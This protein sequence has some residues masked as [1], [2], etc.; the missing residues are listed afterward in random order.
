MKKFL[1]TILLI[2]SVLYIINIGLDVYVSNQLRQS[3]D[4]R[5]VGWNE[6]TQ[7]Q[8]NADMVILGSSRALRQYDPSIMDSI[9]RMK[10][11]NLAINGSCLNR[12]IAKYN[13]YKHYQAKHP[14]YILINVDYHYTLEWTT[15][16]EREQ[17]FPYMTNPFAR[18]QILRVEPFSWPELYIPIY[19]YT[20]YKGLFPILLEKN[21][22]SGVIDGYQGFDVPWD[23]SMYMK[24]TS[25]HFNVND[26]T[27][28]M[29]DFF[30]SERRMEGDLVIFCYAPI[31]IGLT[32][33]V[34]NLSEMYDVYTAFSQKYNIPVLDYTFSDLSRDTVYFYNATHMNKYGAELFSER[35]AH[36]LDSLLH[37]VGDMNLIC[38]NVSVSK[39]N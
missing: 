21:Y 26:S 33:K 17:F 1:L 11:Y 3:R 31:Y 34:D 18:N 23:G 30:L 14:C 5:Y 28:E 29:F 39:V 10:V 7:S 38:P 4:R 27:L 15:G 36:D 32:E 20:T 25:Y 24:R 9:L 13:I 22:D 12:Q 19:R 6:I 37:V 35:L 2:L 16:F 8:I